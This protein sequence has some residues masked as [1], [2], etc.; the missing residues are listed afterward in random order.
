MHQVGHSLHNDEPL[1]IFELLFLLVKLST[2]LRVGTCCTTKFESMHRDSVPK[3]R[4]GNGHTFTSDVALTV[5]MC[6][7]TGS[8]SLPTPALIFMKKLW[9]TVTP[10]LDKLADIKFH[11]PQ[12]SIEVMV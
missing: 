9:V 6:L 12:V 3:S 5:T 10:G 7:F 11:F 8:A 1:H 4:I 2:H